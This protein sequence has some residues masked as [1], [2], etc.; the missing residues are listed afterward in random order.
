[1]KIKK[2]RPA[3]VIL[4]PA[5]TV[6]SLEFYQSIAE[7][8][9]P[10]IPEKCM[11]GSC[12]ERWILAFPLDQLHPSRWQLF[13]ELEPSSGLVVACQKCYTYLHSKD[14]IKIGYYSKDGYIR[15]YVQDRFF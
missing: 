7:N 8:L 15:P 10:V 5:G 1:M 6:S 9:R 14:G 3:E 13:P 2:S 12:N 4:P 11:M